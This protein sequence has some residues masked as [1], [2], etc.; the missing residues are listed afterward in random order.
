MQRGGHMLYR[1]C[2]TEESLHQKAISALTAETGTIEIEI[3]VVYL[4]TP[5]PVEP[6]TWTVRVRGF[7][8]HTPHTRLDLATEDERYF[9]VYLDGTPL[10]FLIQP[11]HT[12]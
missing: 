1:I 11:P 4:H 12:P 7:S 3:E 10:N 9:R 5:I 8:H 2:E 6:E